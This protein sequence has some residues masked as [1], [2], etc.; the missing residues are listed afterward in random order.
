MVRSDPCQYSLKPFPLAILPALSVLEGRLGAFGSPGLRT[1]L[2]LP[3]VQEGVP[4][5][6]GHLIQRFLQ[7]VDE[8]LAYPGGAQA[9]PELELGPSYGDEEALPG[10]GHGP[11]GSSGD[12]G[13]RGGRLRAS[14]MLRDSFKMAMATISQ[15]A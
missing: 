9:P 14:R 12:S 3:S 7:L 11:R 10:W 15:P 8:G 4:I 13:G 5:L 6:L 1:G 2:S